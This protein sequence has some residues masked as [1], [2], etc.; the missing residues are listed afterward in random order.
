[1]IDD[2][3][4]EV[5]SHTSPTHRTEPVTS[6]TSL[7]AMDLDDEI[8]RSLEM[9]DDNLG[10][11][12]APPAEVTSGEAPPVDPGFMP[13]ALP[14]DEDGDGDEDD[15]GAARRSIRRHGSDAWLADVSEDDA[16]DEDADDEDADDE[17]D[18]DAGDAPE[19]DLESLRGRLEGSMD[20]EL[21]E[22]EGTPDGTGGRGRRAGSD[23]TWNN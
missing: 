15:T 11:M 12:D 10:L 9:L 19:D 14:P 3:T 2:F 20:T 5:G 17:D 4:A 23:D 21:E 18:E 6:S 7:P 16:D 1:M 13:N 8:D 22:P